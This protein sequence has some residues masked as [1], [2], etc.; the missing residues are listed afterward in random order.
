MIQP[1]A[2]GLRPGVSRLGAEERRGNSAL[3]RWV[4]FLRKSF[5]LCE[6]QNCRGGPSRLHDSNEIT[7]QGAPFCPRRPGT[8]KARAKAGFFFFYSISSEYQVRTDL[9]PDF[10]RNFGV[11][12]LL[13]QRL[14]L[15]SGREGLD[16]PG[17]GF[18]LQVA[19]CRLQVAGCQRLAVHG[20]LPE[21]YGFTTNWGVG[22]RGFRIRLMRVCAPLLCCLP[23]PRCF[24]PFWDPLK[25][26]YRRLRPRLLGH[27][28]PP[29]RPRPPQ[30]PT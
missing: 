19:G 11:E 16:R 6:L 14:L 10:H 2:G 23:W 25:P 5:F 13:Y 22:F 21:I 15:S 3:F 20:W 7:W 30:P 9:L 27:P 26:R 24:C 17:A 29:R 28:L 8:E 1:G 12:V 18:R 4:K